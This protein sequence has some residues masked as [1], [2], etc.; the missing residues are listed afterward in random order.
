MIHIRGVHKP[1]IIL[2]VWGLLLS[3]EDSLAVESI[4]A[5]CLH[6]CMFIKTT[7]PQVVHLHKDPKGKEIFSDLDPSRRSEKAEK[8]DSQVIN[9]SDL[10]DSDKIAALNSRVARLKET[11]SISNKRIAELEAIVN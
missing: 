2:F 6:K 8:R 10:S 1:I 11:L 7:H 5:S 9:L 3:V 4:H